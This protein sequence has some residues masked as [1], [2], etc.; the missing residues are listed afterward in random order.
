MIKHVV[1]KYI[2]PIPFKAVLF[3]KHNTLIKEADKIIF[4]IIFAYIHRNF[5]TGQQFELPV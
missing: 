4:Q 1:L 2:F 5:C 3:V